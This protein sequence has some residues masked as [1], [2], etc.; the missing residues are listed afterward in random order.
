MD[1]LTYYSDLAVAYPEYITQKQ[2][3]EVCGICH[4]TA[5]NLTRRGEISYE[6][7]ATPTGRIHHIMEVT[8]RIQNGYQVPN[9]MMPS[10][11]EVHL[12]KYAELRRAYLKKH[13]RVLYTNLKTSGKLTEHLAEIEQTARKM[14]EQAVAQMA[15][16]EGVTEELKA[17]DPL[18][19]T[20]L[21]NN[22]RHSAEELVLSD[23]I[24]S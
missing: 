13:R 12:G 5:Y 7:V 9:L 20:G 11:P 14:V 1:L 16:A 15:R 17:T 18:R 3:C 21:M 4:K 23:L 8:Y 24:Y 10:V 2:F 22:L 6:I 19:W